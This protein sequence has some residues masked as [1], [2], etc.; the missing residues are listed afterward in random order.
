[1]SSSEPFAYSQYRLVQEGEEMTCSLAVTEDRVAILDP[2]PVFV[3]GLSSILSHESIVVDHVTDPSAWLAGPSRTAIVLPATQ[4]EELRHIAQLRKRN[5]DLAIV[6]VVDPESTATVWAALAAGAS[7]VLPRGS[8]AERF[9]AVIAAALDGYSL[10]PHQSVSRFALGCST[11]APV[12]LSDG[13]LTILESLANG[14]TTAKLAR[15]L[16]YSVRETHRKLHHLFDTIGVSNRAG[17]IVKATRWGLVA[18][19]TAID[20]DLTIST[21]TRQANGET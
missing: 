16:N 21:E 7:S 14:E 1:M 15:K 4:P 12:D 19:N 17:A 9:V 13:E 3:A 11:P 18:A 6:G 20:L 5:A 2:D 8:E 10:L